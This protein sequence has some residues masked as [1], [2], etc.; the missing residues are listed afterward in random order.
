MTSPPAE[1]SPPMITRFGDYRTT[2]GNP[3]LRA[4]IAEQA[5]VDATWLGARLDVSLAEARFALQFV[6]PL[7]TD[8]GRVLEVGA[9]LGLLSSFLSTTGVDITTIE[10]GGEGFD[11]YR[12]TGRAIRAALGVDHPTHDVAVEDVDRELLGG[13]FDVIFSNNVLEHVHDVGAALT[14]LDA[15]LAPGATMVHN[16][17]NYAV[18]YEPHFGVPLLPLR[19]GATA[20][21]LPR[22]VTDTGLWRS[23]NFVTV[24][25]IRSIATNCDAHV[26]FER[27]LLADA[28]DRL[29][30]PEFAARHTALA[31]LAPILRPLTRVLRTLPASMTTPMIFRWTRPT[32]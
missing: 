16:C 21:I 14:C 13:T 26:T 12:D 27:G 20:R 28:F 23:L 10:P 18:P 1:S 3:D 2:L 11:G 31:R 17:P 24:S 19:P 15:L 9:G 5:G 7:L 22:R 30:E 4:S 8:A 29:R 32:S 25:D 6:A